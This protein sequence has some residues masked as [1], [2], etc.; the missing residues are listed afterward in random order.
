MNKYL[1]SLAIVSQT[2]FFAHAT[3]VNPFEKLMP[4]IYKQAHSWSEKVVTTFDSELQLAYLNLFV[5]DAEQSK[6]TFIKCAEFLQTKADLL[7]PLH[8][9]FVTNM[10][11]IV[12]TYVEEVEKK[13]AQKQNITDTEKQSLW[14][15]LE[16]K[17]QELFA[18]IHAIYYQVLYSHIAKRNSSVLYMFDEN[19]IIPQEKRTRSLP[20]PE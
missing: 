3:T 15:H 17:A 12:Q 20:R 6:K 18:Y 10:M 2:M 14:K 16:T 5:L 4:T 8:E 1:M 11:A 9:E 7:T 13:I 19:G